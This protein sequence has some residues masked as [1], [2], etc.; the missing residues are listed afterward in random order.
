MDTIHEFY[1]KEVG[2]LAAELDEQERFSTENRRLPPW[3]AAVS[4]SPIVLLFIVFS[5]SQRT[6]NSVTG[7]LSLNSPNLNRLNW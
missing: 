2:P 1:V 4:P 7:F 5:M 6:C 3:M